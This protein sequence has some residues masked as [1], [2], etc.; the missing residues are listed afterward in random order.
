MT[1]SPVLRWTD[2]S[3]PSPLVEE[4]TLREIPHRTQ[5]KDKSGNVLRAAETLSLMCM[6]K[7]TVGFEKI[8]L[9]P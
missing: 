6:L 3:S 2:L 8:A 7:K 4:W 9:G 5:K 1:S